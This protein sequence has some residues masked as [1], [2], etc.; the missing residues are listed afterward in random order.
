MKTNELR[1]RSEEELKE[2]V[3]E[4]KRKLQEL[5]FD[6][7]S[8]K[9]KNVREVRKAKKEIARTLTILGEKQHKNKEK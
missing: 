9:V 6:L 2:I 4:L 3:N 8:G 5:R 1:Q 7:V